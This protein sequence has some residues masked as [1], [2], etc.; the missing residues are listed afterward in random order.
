MINNER[1]SNEIIKMIMIKINI[2]II[3]K[4]NITIIKGMKIMVK[5][6]Q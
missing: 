5:Q 3:V 2:I 6:L 4:R 1:N